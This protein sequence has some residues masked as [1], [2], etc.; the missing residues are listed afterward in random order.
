MHEDIKLT[1]RYERNGWPSLAR[2]DLKPPAGWS[3]EALATA[4]QLHHHSLS[5]DGERIAFVWSRD[6]L[7][8]LY[9]VATTGG[10]PSQLTF[11]RA[12]VTAWTDGAPRWS[13][14]GNWLAYTT[15]G[16]V[17][18]LSAAGGLPRK[19][20]DFTASAWS[21]V[22]MGDSNR[23]IVTSERDGREQMLLTDRAGSWPRL[24]VAKAGADV[25]D[26]QP[27]PDDRFVAYVRRPFDDLNRL[28]IRLVEVESGQVR[29]LTGTSK[30]R[31]WSPRWSPD[32][33]ALAFLSER[34]GWNELWLV[35]PDGTGMG[36]LTQAGQ[37]VGDPVWSP[38]GSRIACTVNKGGALHL[39]LVDVASGEIRVLR[40]AAGVHSRPHW[41]PDGR[42]LTVEYESATQPAEIFRVDAASGA[43]TQISYT[44][45]PTFP[46]PLLV[47]PEAVGYP[48]FDGL[49]IPAF[50]YRPAQP[51]G[52]AVVYVHGGPS[53]QYL[54]EWDGLAQ[55]FV[56]KGY[57]WLA[58]NYRGSTGYGRA[59]EEANH[60][61]WGN[62]DRQDCLHGARFLATLPGID[63][64]RIGIYGPSYG[65]YMTACCLANDPE[66][67]FACG[68]DKYGDAN[69]LSSWAQCNRDLRLYSEIFLSHP[70]AN[71]DVYTK[72]SPIHQV[73]NVQ[74]PV[75]ILH[76]LSDDVVPPEGSEEWVEAL[77]TAGKSY[78]YKSYAGEG[79][80][81]LHR[82]TTLDLYSRI[83]RFL[84]WYLL[85]AAVE[86]HH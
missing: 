52:A 73:G 39:A 1:E 75:L 16:H 14:D 32:G 43:A 66:T 47:E 69:T 27:S 31:D 36:Q 77:R 48:S 21:P 78:E 83:E 37:D 62:G 35:Q 12:P 60:R 20:S 79:H 3:L 29:A 2:P 45:S 11:D 58:L 61:E 28:D 64:A 82:Q 80:G 38:D 67:L 4:N 42:W 84:D 30:E 50:L 81:F 9:S 24:L 26:A 5:P 46:P 51:N 85:P 19:I 70:A 7:S 49:A 86:S 33:S 40:Q 22:W 68:I 25:W 44:K 74:K 59:F 8:N 55:Y 53:S 13:P 23:L 54:L 65:G 63:P 18:V 34:S 71:R 15:G 56:A 57:H 17:W 10:W 41:S 6:D 72:S 76:G